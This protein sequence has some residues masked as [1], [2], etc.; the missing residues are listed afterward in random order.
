MEMGRFFI[1]VVLISLFFVGVYFM[2]S[3][4][5]GEEEYKNFFYSFQGENVS[6]IQFYPNMRYKLP[7]I[8]YSISDNCD[9]KKKQDAESAFSILDE[10]TILSFSKVSQGGQ[11]NI[12]CS[13]I[14]PK[15]E[16]EGHFIAG[17]GGPSE[18]INASAYSVI[19]SGKVSLYRT[20]KC[21]SPQVAIHEILH[22]LGFE[23]SNDPNDV[24]YPVTNCEQ[25]LNKKIVDKINE[26]YSVPSAPDLVIEKTNASSSGRYLS[27][28]ITT[29][30]FGLQDSQSSKLVVSADNENIK[31]F[32]LGMIGVGVR[33]VM[34]VENLKL[35]FGSKRVA[36]IVETS[37]NEISKENN[38][39]ELIAL[40]E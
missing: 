38:A 14:A 19:L 32:D 12:L 11:I 29:A 25:Q 30:N 24:M 9:L 10:K 3:L 34:K 36:F 33:K 16:E 4:N 2:L 37:E 8:T 6:K 39:V 35:P 1:L 27:F 17:E 31:E 22:A 26:I 18:I 28:S 7:E 21:S 23:H 15:P 20:E 13:N 5:K 40:G